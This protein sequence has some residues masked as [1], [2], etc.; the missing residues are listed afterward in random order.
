M[1]SGKLEETKEF[2][3]AMNPGSCLSDE[4]VEFTS[5]DA[6]INDLLQIVSSS[7]RSTINAGEV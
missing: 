5:I 2:G 3:T 6:V 7:S 1:G 4:M